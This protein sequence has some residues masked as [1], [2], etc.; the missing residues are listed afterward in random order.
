MEK[1][2]SLKPKRSRTESSK[3]WLLRQLNDPYVHKAKQEG[4]RSRAAYKLVEIDQKFRLFKKGQC[5]VDLGA[6]PGGWSQ[7]AK[8]KVGDNGFVIGVDLVEIDSLP[9]CH[10][11]QGDFTQ[12]AIVEQ[13]TTLLPCK[14]HIVLTDMA[15]SSCGIQ[16]IDHLRIM[17]LLEMALDFCDQ[18]LFPGGHFAAKVFRGGTEATLLSRLKKSFEKVDHFKPQSSRQESTEMYVVAKGFK[19]ILGKEV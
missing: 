12:E 11:I 10:F 5:V 16:K 18:T 13:I 6:A 19:G 9:G 14:P 4:Y 15:P 8:A 2:R 1:V 3:R 7:V 17:N